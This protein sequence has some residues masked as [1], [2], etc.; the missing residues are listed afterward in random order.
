M[1]K[2]IRVGDCTVYIEWLLR[3]ERRYVF[4][5]RIRGGS[6]SGRRLWRS[7][8]HVEG[9]EKLHQLATTRMGEVSHRIVV[10]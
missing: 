8:R 10:G 9:V 3:D 2:V 1:F 5:F 6:V 7:A 4:I